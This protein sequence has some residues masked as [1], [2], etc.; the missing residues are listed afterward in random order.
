[1]GILGVPA[2][3]ADGDASGDRGDGGEGAC[4]EGGVA[5][6]APV[7]KAPFPYF[8]GKRRVAPVVWKAFGDTSNYARRSEL[9]MERAG[10]YPPGKAWR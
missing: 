5:M 8:G 9:P 1:M 7:L 6:N 10:L 4:V 3:R 2:S